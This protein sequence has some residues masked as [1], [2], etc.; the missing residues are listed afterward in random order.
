MTVL[1]Y[2]KQHDGEQIRFGNV[3]TVKLWTRQRI[4]HT[5]CARWRKGVGYA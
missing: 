2:I 5:N 4:I 3:F 1:Y